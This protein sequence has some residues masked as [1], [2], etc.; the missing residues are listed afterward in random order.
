M[1]MTLSYIKLLVL[2]DYCPSFIDNSIELS[3]ILVYSFVT[4][5]VGDPFEMIYDTIES[6]SKGPLAKNEIYKFSALHFYLIC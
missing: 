4:T 5:I 6:G 3:Q 2:D 1:T